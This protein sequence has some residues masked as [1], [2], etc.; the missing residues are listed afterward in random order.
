VNFAEGGF[1]FWHSGGIP[2]TTDSCPN[3][4]LVKIVNIFLE[5]ILTPPF[6]TASEVTFRRVEKRILIS[7]GGS[8]TTELGLL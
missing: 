4:T 3:A 2:R 5:N 7:L 6:F 1:L 8:N